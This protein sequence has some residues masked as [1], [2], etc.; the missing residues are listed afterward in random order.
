MLKIKVLDMSNSVVINQY[1]LGMGNNVDIQSTCLNVIYGTDINYQFGAGV[2]SVSLLI[3]NPDISFR[4]H[5]FLNSIS[6]FFLKK[7]ESIANKYSTE[8]IVYELDDNELNKLPASN[9]WSSAMYFRLVALDY[10]SANYDYALYL[11]AD[12]ICH[13]E[14]N[15]DINLI[16]NSV[17]GVVADDLTVRSKSGKRLEL[18]ELNNSYFNSGVMLVNLKK[19][20]EL[21]ITQQCFSLLSQ[22]NAKYKYKYPDQDV[23]NI[24]LI[25][26]KILLDSKFNTIYTLKNELHDKTHEKY[27]K[28]ITDKVALIHYTGLTKPWHT[29]ANYPSSQPFYIALEKSPWTYNDLKPATKMVEKK[30]EYKHLLKQ[31]K[32]IAG[33]ISGLQYIYAKYFGK[34]R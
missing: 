7:L 31:R 2:S 28:I 26:K 3:N 32:L 8:F 20:H 14:L 23:L 4:F 29:W 30:K 17:C 10:L 1:T 15:L 11:D 6:E 34:K 33:L 12:V 24:L 19:W 9:I 25:D 5:F 18:S 22:P 13:S 27:K 16:K 21:E